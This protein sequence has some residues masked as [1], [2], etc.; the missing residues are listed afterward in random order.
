MTKLTD[1]TNLGAAP[2][3]ADV[4]HLVDVS[5]T[6]ADSAGTSFKLTIA[7]LFSNLVRKTL[8]NANTILA[9]NAND[10][11]LALT[12]SASTFLGRKA[13]GNI[14]AMSITEA[15]TLLAYKQ[16]DITQEI[17]AQTGTSYPLTDADHGKL[18]TLDNGSA[19]ALSVN[20]GLRSDFACMILQK[21]VGVVTVGGT[22]TVNEFSGFTDTAGQWA[23][24][25]ISGLGSNIYVLQGRLA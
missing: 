25:S 11:P 24:A 9:A 5:D 18:V 21:G 23:L 17:N 4:I 1:K 13:S 14:S 2:D 8:F 10:T 16:T 22:A 20:T 7:N 12:V 6:S 3:D 19:I 15:K